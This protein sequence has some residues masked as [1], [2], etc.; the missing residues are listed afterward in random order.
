MV[1]YTFDAKMTLLNSK[2]FKAVAL[3]ANSDIQYLVGTL[4]QDLAKVFKA[5][6]QL[7][8]FHHVE[9]AEKWLHSLEQTA[10]SGPND[11][12]STNLFIPSGKLIKGTKVRS[13]LAVH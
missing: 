4:F 10:V 12:L 13:D 3:V 6:H 1:E 2:L 8:V 9:D 11:I 5:K 7:R